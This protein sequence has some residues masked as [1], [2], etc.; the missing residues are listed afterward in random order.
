MA[1]ADQIGSTYQIAP[2]NG[3][4]KRVP[5]VALLTDEL[6]LDFTLEDEELATELTTEL[7]LD[8]T[9]EELLTT[10]LT[11]ELEL[12]LTLDELLTTELEETPQLAAVTPNGAG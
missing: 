12:D 1:F 8:L 10:E 11:T 6:E 9:L 7:E 4:S 3:L 2:T 5:G